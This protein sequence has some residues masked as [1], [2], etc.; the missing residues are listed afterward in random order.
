MEINEH[1]DIHTQQ[2]GVGGERCEN[3]SVLVGS[4]KNMI[5]PGEIDSRS[6]SFSD[7]GLGPILMPFATLDDPNFDFSNFIDQD[8]PLLISVKGKHSINITFHTHFI[9]ISHRKGM[10]KRRVPDV[11]GPGHLGRGG[12]RGRQPEPPV[13]IA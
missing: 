5:G 1:Q 11:H 3:S 2:I 10:A 9:R 8:T 4:P 6:D 12:C 7:Q 13:P